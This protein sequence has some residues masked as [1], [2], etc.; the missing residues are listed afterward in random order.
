MLSRRSF[1]R[2]V[3]CLGILGALAAI[4]P[5]SAAFFQGAVAGQGTWP[6]QSGNQVGFAA[7]PASVPAAF[8]AANGQTWPGAFSSLTAWPGGTGAQTI[9]AGTFATSGAGT[10][11][12]PYVFAFRDFDALTSGTII[13]LANSIFVGCRFQS[14]SVNNANLHCTVNNVNFIYCSITPRAALWSSPPNAAWPSAGAGLQIH[15]G[16]AAY[17][18]TGGYCVPSTDGYQFGV[19]SASTQMTLDH[20]DIWGFGNSFDI[21]VGS[22]ATIK[23]NACWIHD[24]ANCN[25]VI[26]GTTNY[27]LDGPGYLDGGAAPSNVFITN[28]TIASIGNTNGIAFQAATTAYS[29]ITVTGNYLSGFAAL[30]D[31]CHNVTGNNN[32]T[33]TDNV[34]GTD[35][36][37][38]VF[39]S[40]IQGGTPL[41]NDFS[42]QFGN[43]STNLWRRNTL[44]VLAGT[45]Q[46][47]GTSFTWVPS[48]SGK[49]V[50]PNITLSSSDWSTGP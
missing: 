23:L 8:T 38:V 42:A 37:W 22:T 26:P 45:T 4:E 10:A 21:N 28:C 39:N 12:N 24:G 27:H 18:N 50:L 1:I 49:F 14:N 25:T 34:F 11:G 43:G 16:S 31:M 6:G 41:Y 15:T 47:V 40:V 19:S 46:V 32:L 2:A 30:V 29:N 36:P 44:H 35:L 48:D 17:T 20:C 33:F 7:T 9:S 3:A 5:A 13:S